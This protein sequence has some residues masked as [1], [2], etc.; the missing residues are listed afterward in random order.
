MAIAR[1]VTFEGVSSDRMADMKREIEGGEQPEGLNSKELLILHDAE[2]EKS[3]AIV[4]FETE[5]DYRSGDEVLN[6]MPTDDTP[7][8]RTSV[9]RYAVAV[10]RTM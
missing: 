9:Q 10:H 6:N 1:V 5:E 4:L 3:M 8:Q 7:G 2:S